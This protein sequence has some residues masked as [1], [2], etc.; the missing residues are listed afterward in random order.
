MTSQE[1]GREAAIHNPKLAALARLVGT[2]STSGRHPL[3]PGTSLHGRASFAWLE[4]GA[5]LIMRAEIDEPGIPSGI[6]I[7][8][9]D[10][11]TGECFMLYFDEREISRKYDVDVRSDGLTWRRS[12]PGFSQRMDL[13]VSPDGDAIVS[14]GEFSRDGATWEGDLELTYRRI[15]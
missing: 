13:T 8:G 4:G 11:A 2:W 14:R 12:A 6:A 7:F 10:D 9:S 5:F 15:Q 3:L 1:P